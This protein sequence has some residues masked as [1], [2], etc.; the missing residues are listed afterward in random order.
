MLVQTFGRSCPTALRA[1]ELLVRDG[2]L[3]SRQGYG[4]IVRG[5]STAVKNSDRYRQLLWHPLDFDHRGVL[6]RLVHR[7]ADS[8]P[9]QVA[10]KQGIRAAPDSPPRVGVDLPALRRRASGRGGRRS[11]R[12]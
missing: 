3:E 2:W 12:D 5:R 9:H 6:R 11:P 4:V 10:A 1:L 7:R 8:H